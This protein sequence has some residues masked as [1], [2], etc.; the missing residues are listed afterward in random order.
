MNL[1]KTILL[2]P[3]DY[4]VTPPPDLHYLHA[5]DPAPSLTAL[6]PHSRS[7]IT[8]KLMLP[9]GPPDSPQGSSGGY[10]D[11]CATAPPS[12]PV[13]SPSTD[14]HW[15]AQVP[16]TRTTQLQRQG[17]T[18]LLPSLVGQSRRASTLSAWTHVLRAPGLTLAFQVGRGGTKEAGPRAPRAGESA[19]RREIVGLQF[20]FLAETNACRACLRATAAG[21]ACHRG[22][23]RLR[24][25]PDR[26]QRTTWAQSSWVHVAGLVNCLS[27]HATGTTKAVEAA[28]WGD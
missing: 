8:S 26:P 17:R 6:W 15:A 20:A 22:T 2:V 24:Q 13:E 27:Q 12:P 11:P 14:K 5:A 9:L 23:R 10:L 1:T 3:I 28:P 21:Q 18:S 7:L 16:A 4:L 19:N 25:G